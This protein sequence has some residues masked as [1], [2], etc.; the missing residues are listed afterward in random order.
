MVTN[1]TQSRAQP[2]DVWT[3]GTTLV[4]FTTQQFRSM[5]GSNV[6]LAAASSTAAVCLSAPCST[7]PSPDWS[8]KIHPNQRV[9]CFPGPR[10]CSERACLGGPLAHGSMAGAGPLQHHPALVF[11][12]HS[13]KND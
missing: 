10:R 11:M 12:R 9:L 4:S 6:A 2:V 1:V 13:Q 5:L 8:W 7:K 3:V